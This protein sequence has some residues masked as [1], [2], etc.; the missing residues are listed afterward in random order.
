MNSVVLTIMPEPAT[1]NDLLNKDR[2]DN[3]EEEMSAARNLRQERRGGGGEDSSLDDL[4]SLASGVGGMGAGKRRKTADGLKKD[5]LGRPVM[6]GRSLP[7]GLR[8]QGGR[9][10]SG[11]GPA[12]QNGPGARPSSAGRQSRDADGDV[13]SRL[14]A[15]RLRE[16][17]EKKKREAEGEKGEETEKSPEGEEGEEGGGLR[18]RVSRLKE[19]ADL[20]KRARA[21]IEE[22]ITAPAK[23]GINNLLRWAWGSLIPSFGLSLLYINLHVFLRLVLGDKLFCKLGDEWI[24][25]E[26]KAAAGEAGEIGGKALG[27]VEVMGL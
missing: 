2:L 26:V 18:D 27:R 16:E 17:K 15:G 11:S 4:M 5:N 25:K 9:D 1:I 8:S 14:M 3:P 19:K 22:K 20:K 13:D 7:A 23:Q 24:P 6:P 12:G 10:G 21:K